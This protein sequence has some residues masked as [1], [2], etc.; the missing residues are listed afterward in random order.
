MKYVAAALVTSTEI[1]VNRGRKSRERRALYL[2][3]L[4][5]GRRGSLNIELALLARIELDLD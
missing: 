4:V 5:K 3:F 2:V 1:A